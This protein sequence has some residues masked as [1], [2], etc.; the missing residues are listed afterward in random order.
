MRVE[1]GATATGPLAGVR[2]LDLSTIASGPYC[3]QILGDMGADVVKIETP[4]GDSARFMGGARSGTLTGFFANYNRN[5][6]G[7]VLDLKSDAGANAFRRLAKDADVVLENMRPGVMDRLGIGYEV[8]RAENPKLVY[9]AISGFGPDG[10]YA[11]RPA[12]DMIIQAMTGAATMLSGSPAEPRLVSNVLA[13]KT[14]G[15]NAATAIAGALFERERRGEGQRIDIP[16]LDAFANLLHLDIVASAAFGPP[17]EDSGVG[18]FLFRAWPT[19]DG[20]V[21]VLLIEE[22]QWQAFCRVVGREDWIADERFGSLPG[23]LANATA[24]GD[25]MGSEIAKHTT[26]ILVDGAEREGAVMAAV[27]DLAGLPRR[28]AGRAQR[29]RGRRRARR[30][31][32]ADDPPDRALQ[33]DAVGHPPPRTAARRAHRRGAARGRLQR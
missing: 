4:G 17:P 12:Y 9:A 22:H 27:N 21:V 29:R 2:V 32:R 5:K 18:D 11:N 13:D 16:M 10:P 20:H 28:P 23:R 6:R 1:I 7:I 33:P 8:L 19:S 26:A 25:L 3:G 30:A 24:L 14:A 15:M 31:G